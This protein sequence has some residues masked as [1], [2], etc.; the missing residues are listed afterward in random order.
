MS[1]ENLKLSEKSFSNED[2]SHLLQGGIISI[3]TD[4]RKPDIAGKL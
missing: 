3:P 1:S 4:D 2:N